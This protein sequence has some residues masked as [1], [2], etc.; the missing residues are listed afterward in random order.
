MTL[1]TA[2]FALF[3]LPEEKLSTFRATGLAVGF[4]GLMILLGV[5][6]ADFHADWVAYT[7]CALCTMGYAFSGLWT[8][9]HI[10]PMRLD[11][12]SAVATQLTIG[13]VFCFVV[14]LFS[15]HQITS[16]PLNGVLSALALGVL[17][18]G[19]ALVLNFMLVQRAGAVATSTVTY[20]I[21]VV[22]TLAGALILHEKLHWY[23]PIGAALVLTGIA[24]VQQLI[25]PRNKV[26]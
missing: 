20:A 13:A 18:T 10:S 4:F 22:A 7:A 3:M 12:I 23:E 6:D 15:K 1:W 19:A 9:K 26:S 24:I 17:G 8:R 2:L 14:A 21:P 5:W 11:P 25:K 16:W